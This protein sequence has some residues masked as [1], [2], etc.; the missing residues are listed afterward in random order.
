MGL[1]NMETDAGKTIESLRADSEKASR[2]AQAKR[3]ELENII[4]QGK[5]MLDQ[6]QSQLAAAN[7]AREHSEAALQ[8]ANSQHQQQVMQLNSELENLRGELSARPSIEIDP[9]QLEILQAKVEQQE[10][11][12]DNALRLQTRAEI[13]AA[14]AKNEV[15][16]EVQERCRVESMMRQLIE[17]LC[18]IPELQDLRTSKVS[19]KREL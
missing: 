3:T 2:D 15:N 10:R 11:I 4:E 8:Q 17:K 14:K 13:I 19:F 1:Q 7:Q 5:G 9:E 12:I 6:L 18:Q 16:K